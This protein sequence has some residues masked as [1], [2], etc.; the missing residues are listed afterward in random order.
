MID[1]S[2]P[3]VLQSLE[4]LSKVG[5]LAAGAVMT[6]IGAWKTIVAGWRGACWCLTPKPAG[7]IAEEIACIVENLAKAHKGR[8]GSLEYGN[9]RV[10]KCGTVLAHMVRVID[11][12]KADLHWDAVPME[13]AEK[14]VIRKAFEARMNTLDAEARNSL[15][16]LAAMGK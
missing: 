7:P 11:N 10:L 9:I 5:G 1:F 2:S 16:L 15:R 3:E 14:A 8:D 13:K 4:C 12:G 6:F